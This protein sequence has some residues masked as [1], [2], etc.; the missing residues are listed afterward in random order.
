MLAL[1]LN[2]FAGHGQRFDFRTFIQRQVIGGKLLCSIGLLHLCELLT[3]SHL[4]VSDGVK[5]LLRRFKLDLGGARV[6]IIPAWW[7]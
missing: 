5:A 2:D 7:K 4:M 3:S 6:I 1:V